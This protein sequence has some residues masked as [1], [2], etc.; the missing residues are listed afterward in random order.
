MR[1]GLSGAQVRWLTGLVAAGVA[2][3]PSIG[4]AGI[5]EVGE[6]TATLLAGWR[7]IPQHPLMAQLKQD[8]LSPEHDLAQPG[9][10]LSLGYRS[11]AEMHVSIDLGYAIDRWRLSSGSASAQTVNVLLSGDAPIW[12]RRDFTLYF[13]GGFG[14]AINTF[15][16]NGAA[17]ESNGSALFAKVGLRVRIAGS[18]A[19]VLE[20]RYTYSNSDY[21]ALH[22]SVNVG[23][24]L[25][26]V[27]LQLH[28]ATPDDKGH[29]Q[30]PR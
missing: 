23:G 27:G 30:G 17:T 13:G 12:Q 15:S 18:L 24:N 9:F 20:D 4:Q 29:P 2:L 28:F 7:G 14:Y 22:S 11:D 1:D 19:L 3:A 25:L 10:I 26:A 8:G 5:P 6:G 21:P 16:L